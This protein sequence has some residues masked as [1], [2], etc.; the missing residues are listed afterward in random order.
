MP[1]PPGST[2]VPASDL[3]TTVRRTAGRWMPGRAAEAREASRPT[4]GRTVAAEA[5][6]PPRWGY[7]RGMTDLEL[8]AV[9]Q[10]EQEEEPDRSPDR[11]DPGAWAEA[12]RP[13]LVKTPSATAR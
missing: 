7:C 8:D 5:R 1:M 4:T 10:I 2:A 13:I 11:G 3:T 12:A 9:D 6:R